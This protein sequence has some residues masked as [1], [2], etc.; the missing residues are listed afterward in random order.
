MRAGRTGSFCWCMPML[1]SFKDVLPEYQYTN[2]YPFLLKKTDLS[3]H[4]TP[5]HSSPTR[6]MLNR[7]IESSNGLTRFGK[8]PW[9]LEGNYPP[10]HSLNAPAL[11]L[12]LLWFSL[13]SISDGLVPAP[14]SS[15]STAYMSSTRDT[16][17]LYASPGIILEKGDRA[18][19]HAGVEKEQV[20]QYAIVV[21]IHPNCH[22]NFLSIC[23]LIKYFIC[24]LPVAMHGHFA[25][26]YIYIHTHI[27]I[28]TYTYTH[29]CGYNK[30]NIYAVNLHSTPL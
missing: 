14:T 11:P 25:C 21:F 17:T 24:L 15:P 2:F 27:H 28:Y 19:Y 22:W 20:F 12:S 10:C 1:L 5:F 8:D 16:I 29:N 7:P 18:L 6:T 23:S 30:Y 13:L 26:V 9:Q 3:D 4:H